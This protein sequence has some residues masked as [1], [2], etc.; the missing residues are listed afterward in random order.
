MATVAIIHRATLTPSKLELLAAWL[1]TRAWFPADAAGLERVAAYR[2][3]D[4]D[5]E[6]G[7]ETF[8]VRSGGGPLVQVPLTYRGAPLDGH[9]AWLVGTTEHSVLGRRWVYD[10]CGD[11]VYAATLATTILTGG[12]EA[13]EYVDVDGRMQRRE[14]PTRVRGTGGPAGTGTG[15]GYE[16][17][18]VEDG[19]PTVVVTPGLDLIVPRLLADVDGE[20][21]PDVA[22]PS[23]TGTWPGQATPVRLAHVVLRQPAG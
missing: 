22:A 3:D 8:L 12:S 21:A 9:E 17:L 16:V 7:V 20:S 23:L 10:G 6:V 13:E 11:P 15:T 14:T 2:F 19:D 5:G 4:P 18:R 1:P